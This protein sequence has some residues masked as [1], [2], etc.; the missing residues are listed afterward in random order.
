MVEQEAANS[1]L[2]QQVC[3]VKQELQEAQQASEASLAGMKEEAEG[4]RRTHQSE[5]AGWTAG[6]GIGWA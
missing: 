4:M 5:V 1:R 3:R 6:L 2:V